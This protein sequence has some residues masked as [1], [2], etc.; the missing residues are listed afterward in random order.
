MG[1]IQRAYRELTADPAL[2]EALSGAQNGKRGGTVPSYL[3]SQINNYQ[4]GL[5]RLL[6]G[7]GGT[8]ASLFL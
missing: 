5:D 7:G 4:A 6:G 1:K 3:T 2:K 8:N